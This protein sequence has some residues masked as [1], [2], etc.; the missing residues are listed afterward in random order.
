MLLSTFFF[1]SFF[2]FGKGG[3]D[4]KTLSTKEKKKVKSL[5]QPDQQTPLYWC[6]R[7]I[8]LTL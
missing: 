6:L 1:F 2:F 7:A 3:G 4:A 5:P 8:K